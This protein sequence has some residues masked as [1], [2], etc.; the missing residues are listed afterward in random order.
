MNKIN[1]PG[2]DPNMI[3]NNITPFEP[4]HPGYLLKDELDSRK[5]TQAKFAETVGLKPSLINEIIKGKR[6]INTQL[7]LILE[8]AL[9]VPASMWLNLQ[10]AYNMQLAKADDSF[11]SRL[12]S[13]RKISAVF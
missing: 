3:A 4:T 1:I 6:S 13:I 12:A 10:N 7:A 11:M 9:D 5:I 8:A 2:I